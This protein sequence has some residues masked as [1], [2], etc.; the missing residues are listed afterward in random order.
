MVV[1]VNQRTR[2]SSKTMDG[3]QQRVEANILLLGADNVGK[4]GK[5]YY[6]YCHLLLS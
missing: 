1:Q 2:N 6:S 3:H 4:S 5:E